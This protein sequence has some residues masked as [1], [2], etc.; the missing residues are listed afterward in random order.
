MHH[1]FCFIIDHTW[2]GPSYLLI[3]PTLTILI[4][5]Y[6]FPPG[7]DA[8]TDSNHNLVT[9]TAEV[10][11]PS[12]Q[13][14][15]LS[16]M[17]SSLLGNMRHDFIQPPLK[18]I[19]MEHE[20][21]VTQAETTTSA[22]ISSSLSIIDSSSAIATTSPL[23]VSTPATIATT[24]DLPQNSQGAKPKNKVTL[25]SRMDSLEERFTPL[26]NKIEGFDNTLK[27]LI[28][29]LRNKGDA[30]YDD[31]RI[32]SDSDDDDEENVTVNP[33]FSHGSIHVPPAPATKSTF[34]PPLPPTQSLKTTAPVIF[35]T[36]SQ[37]AATATPL[38]PASMP[39][40]AFP[41][42][43]TGSTSATM[44]T[45]S[46]STGT[47]IFPHSFP[48]TP[49]ILPSP[50]AMDTGLVTIQISERNQNKILAGQYVDF[51][52]LANPNKTPS[53]PPAVVQTEYGNFLI[54]AAS[55]PKKTKEISQNDWHKAFYAFQAVHTKRFPGEAAQ[56]FA[57]GHLITT[58]M[59]DGANW[60]GYDESFRKQ[61]E[62][63][64]VKYRWDQFHTVFYNLAYK[65][66]TKSHDTDA[67]TS[68]SKSNNSFRATALGKRVPPGFCYYYHDPTSKCPDINSCSY[69]H[70]CPECGEAHTI[71][72]HDT[73]FKFKRSKFSPR[74]DSRKFKGNVTRTP[75]QQ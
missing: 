60:R 35:P 19:R 27:V 74:R 21:L 73:L 9:V 63:Q 55:T 71:F 30:A 64:V 24:G 11:P 10:H 75:Q 17:F 58:L 3:L 39:A 16:P 66:D 47:I 29:T 61:R 41:P 56:L 22:S 48:T 13:V 23:A 59:E 15:N 49:S 53:L 68:S 20:N 2:Y 7:G 32:G 67:N 6:S 42:H 26:E 34:I 36:A 45:S 33:N 1:Y 46:A 31:T 54:P 69:K 51:K 65:P 37:I 44:A 18:K 38:V 12:Y 50:V 8:P 14:P 57:Y 25:R 28:E 5:S 40:P 70:K 62:V 52:E 43:T 72:R 4:L